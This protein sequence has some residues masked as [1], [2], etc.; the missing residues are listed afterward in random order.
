MVQHAVTRLL[1]ASNIHMQ[2]LCML[3]EPL[4]HAKMHSSHACCAS[5]AASAAVH[6]CTVKRPKSDTI[7]N[8][9]GWSVVRMGTVTLAYA[10]KLHVSKHGV[11]QL[12]GVGLY[13]AHVH[14]QH[15]GYHRGIAYYPTP[16]LCQS[17]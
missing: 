17:R 7:S 2:S 6:L 14:C 10:V 12:A 3:D 15:R 8:I 5:A 1:E 9:A 11:F 4:Q 16:F 13:T